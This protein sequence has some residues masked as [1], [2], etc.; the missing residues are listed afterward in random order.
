MV[1]PI[2]V[3]GACPSEEPA[4]DMVHLMNV[5]RK[6][7]ENPTLSYTAAEMI[8]H[9]QLETGTCD[10]EQDKNKSNSCVMQSN[11]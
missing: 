3:G 5:F 6:I 10:C 1:I 4:F 7:K 11:L 8:L 9:Q 2:N